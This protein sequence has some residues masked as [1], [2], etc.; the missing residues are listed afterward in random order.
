MYQ[1][2]RTPVRMFLTLHFFWNSSNMDANPQSWTTARC[3]PKSRAK[4]SQNGFGEQRHQKNKPS[5]SV[6]HLVYEHK[7]ILKPRIIYSFVFIHPNLLPHFFLVSLLFLGSL[8][9]NKNHHKEMHPR[10]SPDRP[11]D[12]LLGLPGVEGLLGLKGA[13]DP[14]RGRGGLANIWNG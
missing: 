8:Y 5:S 2:P 6:K 14:G 9:E 3:Q 1:L 11:C 4:T 10:N 12:G 7:T 13:C